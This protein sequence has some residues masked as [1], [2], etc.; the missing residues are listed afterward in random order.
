MNTEGLFPRKTQGWLLL[1]I[2]AISFYVGYYLVLYPQLYAGYLSAFWW[3]APY[4]VGGD[5]SQVA[6]TMRSPQFISE[7]VERSLVVY[8]TNKTGEPLKDIF[9]T[10]SP[11]E[12]DRLAVEVSTVRTRLGFSAPESGNVLPNFARFEY[13]PPYSTVPAIFY[14]YGNNISQGDEIAL[15]IYR[16]STQLTGAA[17]MKADRYK[18]FQHSLIETILLPPW[19]NG[20]LAV[21]ALLAVKL[22][23]DLM[24][25]Q[26]DRNN[27]GCHNE[28]NSRQKLTSSIKRGMARFLASFLTIIGWSLIFNRLL[29]WGITF[30]SAPNFPE[31]RLGWE[32]ALL[33]VGLVALI[34]PY[35]PAMLYQDRTTRANKYH[36]KFSTIPPSSSPGGAEQSRG[37]PAQPSPDGIAQ[38]E[39]T[40]PVNERACPGSHKVTQLD[41]RY[42]PI[43]GSKLD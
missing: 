3:N 5:D 36:G 38:S 9:I 35:L 41:A 22:V 10:V 13:I 12:K 29:F 7:F 33:I 34:L 1:L 43:C 27:S 4:S 14:I 31:L 6:I 26:N 19:S 11:S 30:F 18:T 42:C 23:E 28:N 39:G 37:S 40:S 25:D 21:L 15:Q 8:V 16:N 32:D 2:L 17:K 20:V 24:P